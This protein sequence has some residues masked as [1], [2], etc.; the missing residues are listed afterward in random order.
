MIVSKMQMLSEFPDGM[1]VTVKR[2][3]NSWEA[4]TQSPNHVAYADC[5]IPV[6]RYAA[7]LRTEYD[8]AD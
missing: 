5:V 7:I 4:A 1:T 6:A 3:R 2:F 8:L